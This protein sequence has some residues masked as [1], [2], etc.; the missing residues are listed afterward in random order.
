MNWF[1]GCK[2]TQEVKNKFRGLCKQY[3]PDVSGSDTLEEMKQ[4]NNQYHDRLSSL[5]G[6]TSMGT[7][8]K[9]HT[10]RYNA[11]VEQEIMDKI[12]EILTVQAERGKISW[13]I[14]LIGTWIWISGTMK[15]DRLLLGKGTKELPGLKMRWHGKRG[16]WF[17]GPKG[18]HSRYRKNMSND[19]LRTAFGATQFRSEEEKQQARIA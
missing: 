10:Y 19:N 4:I 13:T 18:S 16:M 12:A 1:S 8:G 2:T 5:N 9:E 7:D 3:H 15:E 14:E 11:A 17:K 6:Q